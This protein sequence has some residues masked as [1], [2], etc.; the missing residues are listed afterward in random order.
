MTKR[1]ASIK[2]ETRTLGIDLCNPNPVGVVFRGSDFIDGVIVFSSKRPL[3]NRKISAWITK[4][5]FFPELRLTMIHDPQERLDSIA[6]ERVTNLSVIETL[7]SGEKSSKGF[8]FYR[9]GS[10]GFQLRSRLPN[11]LIE[12]ILS[13]TS[14]NAS[15]PEPVRV[16][17]ALSKILP[18]KEAIF[19]ANK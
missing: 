6:L 11:A 17:H 18:E 16:A 1:Q 7:S 13:V 3:N 9:R 10:S 15:L 14:I 12:G 2:K 4:L 8:A 5:R 19:Q